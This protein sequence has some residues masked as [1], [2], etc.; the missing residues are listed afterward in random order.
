MPSRTR[1]WSSPTITR[2]AEPRTAAGYGPGMPTRD[3]VCEV[4]RGGG[5][6]VGLSRLPRCVGR[7]KVADVWAGRVLVVDDDPGFRV[8]ARE[9][10]AL[11]GYEVV[12]EAGTVVDALVAA[13]AVRP[14][15]VLLDVH[16]PGTDGL[17]G[18]ALLRAGSE[19]PPRV[20]LMSAEV[21]AV[22]A[23]VVHQTG[24]VGFVRKVDLAVTDL[25]PYLSG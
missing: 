6:S 9:L 17:T 20:L 13:A 10:L 23:E 15:A 25:A 22:P 2:S 7:E 3:G 21:D 19:P 14:T 5:S 24:A 12:G 4:R 11:R 16:L 8:L 18:A 1:G